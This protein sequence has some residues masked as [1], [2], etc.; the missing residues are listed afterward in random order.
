MNPL[1]D[2]GVMLFGIGQESVLAIQLFSQIKKGDISVSL[3]T[4]LL[5]VGLLLLITSS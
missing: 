1:G 5:S 3:K 4:P 2:N